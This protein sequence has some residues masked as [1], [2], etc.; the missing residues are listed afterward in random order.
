MIAMRMRVEVLKL[1]VLKLVMVIL[2]QQY[3]QPFL[4]L[5]KIN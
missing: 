3:R 4:D 1:V 2:L 5:R